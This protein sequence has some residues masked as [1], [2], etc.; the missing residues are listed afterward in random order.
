MSSSPPTAARSLL[1]LI[2]LALAPLWL[3]GLF[4]RGLWTPDEPREADI[5]WR[6]S[7]QDERALP[8]LAGVPFL[9]KPP[10]SYWMAAGAIATLGDSPAAARAPNLLYAIIAALAV[11]ALALAMQ[12]PTMPALIAAL[13]AASALTAY[14]VEIWL[15]PDACL[16]AGCAV[17]LLGAWRGLEAPAGARKLAGYALLHL[18]AAV[19]FMAKSAPGWIV[20]ALALLALIVWERRWS[21]LRRWELY[22]GLAL[23]AL[24]IGPWVLAVARTAHGSDALVSLFWH[25]LVGRF[26]Q[27][28]AP[29]GLDY[30]TG[31]HNTPAKYLLE[32][33]L[34]LLPWT[35]LVAAALASA[36]RGIRAGGAR[37]TA[38]RFALCAG[39]PFLLLLSLAATARDI[40]AAPALL[41]FGLLA[42]LWA[43]Q[44]QRAP[45]RLDRVAVPATL[46]LIA[47][48][49][50]VFAAA[51]GVLAASGALAWR[52]GVAAAAGVLVVV[53]LA[54]SFAWRALRQGAL[55]G[56]LAWAY[57]AYAAALCLAARPILPVIDRWQNLPALAARIHADTAH[58]PLALLDPDETTLAMLDHGLRTSFTVL[59]GAATPGAAVSEWFA[60]RG[61]TARVLVL[62]PGHAGGAVTELLARYH[63][64]PAPDDGV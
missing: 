56:S 8:Q 39:I 46:A 36:G 38:W 37:A 52:S 40:Y 25:N 23:Q 53:A 12:L 3:V 29:A 34:D 19:G 50:L 7:W 20:P 42:G 14:R 18:G 17:A 16:L 54:L 55:P 33:P 15:A 31:H 61:P 58:Q 13:V 57:A 21:E 41:G 30:T 43:D 10:L 51:L 28:A 9:E 32:L 48:M 27:V 2:V 26:T 49:S 62:L 22:A 5:A 44:A 4:G 59:T 45:T 11:G 6:M 24:I 1:P 63:R 35:L 60:L 64:W 47:L